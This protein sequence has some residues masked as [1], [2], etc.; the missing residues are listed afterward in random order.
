MNCVFPRFYAWIFISV[1]LDLH[2][3]IVAHNEILKAFIKQRKERPNKK[4]VSIFCQTF[5]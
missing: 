5:Q 3:L 2:I 1:R 4:D